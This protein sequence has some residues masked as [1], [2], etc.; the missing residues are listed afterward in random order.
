MSS[1]LVFLL[2]LLHL[3]LFATKALKFFQLPLLFK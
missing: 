1:L 2:L 3:E